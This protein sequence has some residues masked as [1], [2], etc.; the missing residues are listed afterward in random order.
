MV[1]IILTTWVDKCLLI[2]GKLMVGVIFDP[3]TP[4][5]TFT[6]GLALYEQYVYENDVVESEAA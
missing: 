2:N 6:E 1:N 4:G 3:C 5:Q